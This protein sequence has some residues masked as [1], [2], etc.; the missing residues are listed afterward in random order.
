MAYTQEKPIVFRIPKTKPELKKRFD[1]AVK[2][3]GATKVII[4]SLEKTLTA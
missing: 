4:T 1:K 3:S 2:K